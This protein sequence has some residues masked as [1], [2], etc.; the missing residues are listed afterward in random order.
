MEVKSFLSQHRT[1]CDVE[2]QS[3]KRALQILS[4]LITEDLPELDPDEVFMSM[5]ARERLGSTGLGKG[6]AIP[7][8]RLKNCTQAVAALMQLHNG[9]DYDAIDGE[10]VDLVFALMVPEDSHDTHL[11]VLAALVERLNQPD[12]L[13]AIRAAKDQEALYQA[14]IS[15]D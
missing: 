5:T 9:I 10:P 4:Q 3:K 6:V 15:L 13:Q 7:H 1:A 8:C 14:A 12:Y 2:A 11:Q